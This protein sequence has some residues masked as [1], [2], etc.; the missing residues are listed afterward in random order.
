MSADRFE[1]MGSLPD[2]MMLQAVAVLD[3]RNDNGA[4]DGRRSVVVA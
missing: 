1:F 2:L 4:R 3:D